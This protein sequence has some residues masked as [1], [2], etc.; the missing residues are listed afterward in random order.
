MLPRNLRQEAL[1]RAYVRAVA[2]RAGVICG[3]TDN[4]FGFDMILRAV[5]VHGGQFWDSGP[6]IDLQLKSTT[7]A[8]VRDAEVFYDLEVRAYDLLRQE[9]GDRLRLLVVLVL[10]EDEALWLSQSVEELVLRRCAYWKS[11]RGAA[12]TTNQAT[13]RIAI[14]RA[15]VFSAEAL[16]RLLAEAGGGDS[17]E[18]VP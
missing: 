14:P 1:S 2:A 5:V 10:P 6:Q 17:G 7:R 18:N 8:D 3:G 15:N 11:L 4:D 9:T 12:P 16:E 13:V